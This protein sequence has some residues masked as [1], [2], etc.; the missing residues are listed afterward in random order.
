MAEQ[1]AAG[2]GPRWWVITGPTATGKS[3]VALEL[4]ER[5]PVEII[6]V[7]SMQLYRGMDIGTAK[8]G[9][10]ERARVPHHLV[11]VLD[12]EESCN[13]ARFCR[14]A[15]EAAAGIL[16][17]G[18][19]PLLVGG[20]AMYLKGL[21]WGLM[22]APGRDPGVRRSLEEE[23]QRAGSAALHA[24]LKA[25]DPVAAERIHPN[26]VQRLMRA[27]EYVVLTGRPI[28]RGQQQFEGDP[29]VAHAM[30]GL[31]RDRAE[32]YE[33]VERRVDRMIA[34]GLLDEVRGL[35]GRIGPQAGQALGYK[36]LMAH[37]EGRATLEEAVAD[38][39]R[40]TRRYAKHQLT[41]FRHFPT[42]QW[43]D[44]G[45]EE[46]PAEAAVR[47]EALLKGSA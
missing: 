6:S 28:S 17:R 2:N 26:D 24:R 16:A 21:L 31:R 36:E 23:L 46:S 29:A 15:R 39:K 40:R 32:L 35:Q 34:D 12:P 22:P 41:W 13:V 47:C 7:D 1:Q 43:L 30:V 8:P 45:A 11:D 18:R 25:A 9:P 38:V 37:L 19:R 5:H 42:L 33:R 10:G 44:L 3:A 27:L 14:L 20:S 4:A